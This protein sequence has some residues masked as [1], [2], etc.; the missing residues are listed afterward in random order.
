MDGAGQARGAIGVDAG[1]TRPSRPQAQVEFAGV[2]DPVRLRQMV[3]VEANPHG[4]AIAAIDG[5]VAAPPHAKVDATRRPSLPVRLGAQVVAI[6]LA[7]TAASGQVKGVR[8]HVVVVPKGHPSS[9]ALRGETL[10]AGDAR[11]HEGF[12]V[13]E[14]RPGAVLGEVHDGGG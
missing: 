11:R 7:A 13:V 2:G 6:L 9:F 5:D 10:L 1:P 14:A 12:E 8:V 4:P 3:G